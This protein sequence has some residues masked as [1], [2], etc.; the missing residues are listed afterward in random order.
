[1]EN[2]SIEST[3]GTKCD[4]VCNKEWFQ[5]L[6]NAHLFVQNPKKQMVL[7]GNPQGEGN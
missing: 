4:S 3:N 5:S 7:K 2:N 1:M 6:P